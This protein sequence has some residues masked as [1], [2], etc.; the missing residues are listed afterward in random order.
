LDPLPLVEE[1]DDELSLA[2]D[3][4]EELVE[5]APSLV[6][7][8]LDAALSDEDLSDEEAPERLSVR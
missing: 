5:D 7:E 3:E 8:P 1:D 6:E 2:G 4:V